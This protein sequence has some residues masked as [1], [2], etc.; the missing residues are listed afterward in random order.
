MRVMML[1]ADEEM[2]KEVTGRKRMLVL[3][4]R[5]P[6][7]PATSGASMASRLDI[8]PT[9]QEDCRCSAFPELS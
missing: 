3:W 1:S 5:V 2:D 9:Y 8:S 7:P 4:L 6:Q